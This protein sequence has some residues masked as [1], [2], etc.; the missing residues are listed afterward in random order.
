MRVVLLTSNAIRHKY[1]ANH[2]ANHLA[3]SIEE[4]LVISESKKNDS[5]STEEIISSEIDQHFFERFK[6]EQKFFSNNDYF[7]CN[8]VPVL[9]NE[10]NLSYVYDIIKKFNP[11]LIIAFGTSIIKEPLLSLLKPGRF[12]NLHLGLSPYYR[13]S[14][15]NFWPFV[16][17]ELEY[18]GSTILH[19]DPGVD[20]GDIVTHVLPKIEIGDNVHAIGCKVI[21]ESVKKLI[22]CI[23]II[24]RDE[25]LPRTK[26]WKISDSKYYKMADFTIESLQKYH[27]NLKSKMIERFLINKNNNLK[28]IL[29]I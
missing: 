2:L 11:D 16:N 29:S 28:L 21:K 20:T 15:T 23:E 5:L 1:V 24:K 12:I 4:F 6:T 9:H 25:L 27:Q 17:N 18:V 22:A 26:Q 19:I 10:T 13:G 3:D 8:V 7:S 14:G